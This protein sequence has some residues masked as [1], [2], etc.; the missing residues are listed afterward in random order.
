MSTAT[1]PGHAANPS[2]I[3]QTFNS[4]QQTAALKAGIE[5]DLFT[6]IS[7]G[8]HTPEAIATAVH[9]STRAVRILC[10]YLTMMGFL[11]KDNGAY[12][13]TPESSLFLVKSSP[14]YMGGAARFILD[15]KLM[16]PFNDLA[17]V[18]R[19]GKTTL[20]EQGTVSYDN[21]IWVE[22]AEAMAPMQFMA[23]QEI[24]GIVAGEGAI[25]VLD[26]AAGHGLFGIAIAQANPMARITACDWAHVL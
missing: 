17:Q 1:T 21:P 15:P 11:T 10:D 19:T 23:S 22:F 18:V 7:K 24:A 9:G 13:L 6:E 20:P 16:A 3:F 14:G 8:S 2:L 4:Y 12:S 5:L 26:I 25:E